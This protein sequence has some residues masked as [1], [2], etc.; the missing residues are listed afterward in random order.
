MVFGTGCDIVEH[1]EIINLN[2]GSDI[3]IQKESS[4]IKNC[5]SILKNR[6]SFL[7]GRFA[8]KE[9]VLKCLGLGMQ[10]GIAL[11]DIQVLQTKR[12]KPLIE[13]FNETKRIADELQ[14]NFWHIS[15]THGSNYSIAFVIAENK[16]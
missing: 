10:D 5:K 14:I 16:Y 7:A 4:R 15:I 2:W 8:A 3:F 11:T 9:A 13:L 1:N 6:I 12:G